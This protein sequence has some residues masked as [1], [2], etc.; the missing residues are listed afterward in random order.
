[1]SETSIT[2]EVHHLID[3]KLSAGY[4]VNPAWV[5][6][7]LL[8]KHDKIE[9]DDVEF[10]RVCASKELYRIVSG[11]VG[12]YNPRGK[13]DEQLTLPGWKRLVKAYPIERNGD[14]VLVPIDKCTDAEL[15]AHAASLDEMARGCR[16]HA[17][18]LRQYLKSRKIAA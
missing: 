7:E 13:T 16:A 4:P 2:D 15:Q 3:D 17:A 1:M 11:A 12:R 14:T 8:A 5:V 9:G 10:Y 6:T 18:E